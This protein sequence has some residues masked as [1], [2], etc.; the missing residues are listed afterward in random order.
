M[1]RRPIAI[2]D[3]A[4]GRHPSIIYDTA[5]GVCCPGAVPAEARQPLLIDTFDGVPGLSSL[6]QG[7]PYGIGMLTGS[8]IWRYGAAFITAIYATCSM[9]CRR[10]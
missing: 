4:A 8:F 1:L 10:C 6:F 2:R 5:S 3:R 9:R 7:P